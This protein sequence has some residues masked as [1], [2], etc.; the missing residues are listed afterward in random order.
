MSYLDA[1]FLITKHGRTFYSI[2]V[3]KY[4]L[5]KQGLML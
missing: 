2:I 3:N 4:Y 5:Y 1:P